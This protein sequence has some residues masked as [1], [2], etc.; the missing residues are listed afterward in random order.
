MMIFKKYITQIF[1]KKNKIIYQISLD[2]FE[3]ELPFLKAVGVNA[4]NDY[5]KKL[6]YRKKKYI[7]NFTFLN[8]LS[9]FYPNLNLK[10]T[11][12]FERYFI[13]ICYKDEIFFSFESSDLNDYMIFLKALKFN[14][15]LN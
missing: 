1:L 2:N 6:K 10:I 15:K 5:N 3:N 8:N 9:S 14:F 4:G 11:Y 12:E 13:N 7:E